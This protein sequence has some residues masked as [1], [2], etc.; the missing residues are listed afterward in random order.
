MNKYVSIIIPTPSLETYIQDYKFKYDFF[1]KKGI[2]VHITLIYHIPLDKYHKNKDKIIKIMQFILNA[3]KNKKLEVEKVIQSDKLLALGLAHDDVQLIKKLQK[4]I[5]DIL[6]L[7]N[8]TYSQNKFL[9]H[10]TIFTGQQ[11]PGWKNANLIKKDLTS[12]LPLKLDIN[13][14]WILKIDP[15]KNI[16]TI[17]EIITR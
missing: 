1:T 15:K 12:R 3:L 7:K 10:I 17:L 13:K 5:S 6:D 16:P 11:N 4:K 8:N 9:P 14:V 2:P